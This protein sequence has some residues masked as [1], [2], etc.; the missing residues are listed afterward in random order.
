MIADV[1]TGEGHEVTQAP[2]GEDALALLASDGFDAVFT[3]FHMPGMMGDEFISHL[4]D[5]SPDLPV[6]V[7]TSYSDTEAF[8]N[9]D[10]SAVARVV[11]KPFKS[12]DLLS[13][14]REI[15]Q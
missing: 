14:L 9:L 8:G 5:R 6:V 7:V 13:A 15:L 1:L 3:D 12:E 4:G 2:G 11:E 10:R